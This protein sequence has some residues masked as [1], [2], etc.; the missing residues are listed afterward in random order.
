MDE[1]GLQASCS[2]SASVSGVAGSMNQGSTPSPPETRDVG[3]VKRPH[4]WFTSP[5]WLCLRSPGAFV[6]EASVDSGGTKCAG[7]AA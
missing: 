1:K 6:S 5:R 7:V 4:Q 3:P 2:V